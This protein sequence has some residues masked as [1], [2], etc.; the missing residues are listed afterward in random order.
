MFALSILIAYSVVILVVDAVL[1]IYIY[2][3]CF[4]GHVGLPYIMV[5][6]VGPCMLVHVCWSC[7]LGM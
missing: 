2:I 1:D 6:Y 4:V 5:I 7:M 3:I